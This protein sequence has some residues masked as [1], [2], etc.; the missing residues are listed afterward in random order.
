MRN[1]M[2]GVVTA[3][4]AF[5][6]ASP[7]P[8]PAQG[9]I[10]LV[11][12]VVVG[13]GSDER[14]VRHA[15]VTLTG[16]TLTMP[17]VADTDTAGAY[18]FDRL[19]PGGF[20]ISAQK[21]G[22]V[23]LEA[24]AVPDQV[25]TMV[26][27]GAIEGIVSDG[28]GDPVMN[29]AVAALQPQ[30]AGA[31]PKVAAETRTDDLGRYR[32]HGLDAGDYVV[33]AATD[34]AYL[35]NTGLAPGQKMPEANN[36]FYPAATVLENAKAVHV[37]LGRDA[38]G[39]DVALTPNPPIADPAGKPPRPPEEPKGSGRIAGKI[40]DATSGKPL[41]GARLL[42]LPTEGIRITNWTSTDAQGRYEYTGL[43][44][45]KYI[46]QMQADGHLTLEYGRKRPGES[47]LP[48]E[49]ADGQNVAADMA[50]PRAGAVEGTLTD[51]FG[52]PA[53]GVVVQIARKQ[54]AAGRQRLVPMP[55]RIAPLATDD[56]GHYRIIGPEPGE[57][58]LV[59]LSGAF[60]DQ[61][62]AG[63]FAP[64]FYPGTSDAGGAVPISV[65][66]GADTL[67][68]SFSLAPSRTVSVSGTVVDSDGRP[69]AGR[70]TLLLMAPDR[71]HR[72]ETN[73]ARGITAP[74][75][76]FLFRNV[77]QGSYT[78]QGF[79]PPP[80]GYR[81]PMNLGAMPFGWAAV[82]AGDADVDGVVLKVT[83]GTTLRGKVTLEEGGGPPLTAEQVHVSPIPVEFDSAPIGG[84]P[85]PSET[86][87]DWTFEVTHLSGQRRVF[88]S[89]ASP[90]WTL[91]KVLHDGI[92]VTD[93]PLDFR[94]KDVANVEIVL[95]PKVTRVSG[96]VSDESG[97]VS[98]YAVVIF[99]SDP[100]RWIDRSR[101]VVLARGA[102]QGRFDVRA[103]PP[104]D[105]LAV[106]VPNVA[107]TEWMDPEFLQA[108]RPLASSFSLQEGESKTLELKLKKRP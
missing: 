1:L 77:P 69:I 50:L 75:G 70:G 64:T 3:L 35:Q 55:T 53:P 102:L 12:R 72:P 63:G 78:L 74:D 101:F 83:N 107:G 68:L 23:K 13:S 67:G 103:L 14:P 51:E 6:Q 30:A 58:F 89:V 52:D 11:G 15:R 8:P 26:R 39:I 46:L 84:G 32:L 49:V 90:G 76:A 71:M 106:A 108:L 93:T 28:N 104:E 33:R 61:N 4:F 94:T 25:M 59:A 5:L 85:S 18:R 42:L 7:P 36:A 91:K 57:Y 44:P 29:V 86:H 40:T 2:F 66:P 97:P 92:D 99:A 98:E 56:R 31:A 105:Y 100:N 95:T 88:V 47:G 41:K 48:I 22:F 96:T 38:S 37:V 82:T 16:G 9:M 79:G 62:E 43:A 17:R 19:P 65:A 20:R 10:A 27:G 73:I 45:R 21:P 54:Y 34:R 80:P 24:P 60:S 87:E 81:G